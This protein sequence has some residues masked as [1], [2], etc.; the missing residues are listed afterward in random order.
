VLLVD[1]DRVVLNLLAEGL[2]EQ[3]YTVAPAISGADALRLVEE[4][5][6]DLA[7]LDMRMPGLSGLDLA[8]AFRTRGNPPFVFLSAFC[9][10][11][12]VRDAADAGAMGYLTKPVDMPQLVPFIEASM[13]RARELESLRSTTGHLER[14]LSSEQ[15]THTA[16]GI[17]MVHKMLDRQQAFDYVRA[18]ARSQRRKIGDVA[19]EIIA[20]VEVLN[21]SIGDN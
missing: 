14:A 20:A 1:D 13:A 10:E 11:S 2:R 7:V 6:F 18:R 3:G 19:E 8:R 21:R 9:D 15:K 4:Q 17:V 12:V 5:D 16:V